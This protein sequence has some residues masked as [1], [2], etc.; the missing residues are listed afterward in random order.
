MV[1]LSSYQGGLRTGPSARSSSPAFLQGRPVQLPRS[2]NH[3]T[4]SWKNLA[5]R[6]LAQVFATPQ[7]PQRAPAPSPAT[8][9]PVYDRA[10]IK[11]FVVGFRR[12]SDQGQWDVSSRPRGDAKKKKER[13]T[14][15]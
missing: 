13:D 11:V 7:G 3:V 4:C 8:P 5:G 12:G 14:V 10:T 9:D 15:C 6:I 2:S 1:V